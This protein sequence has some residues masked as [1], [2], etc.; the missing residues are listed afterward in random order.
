MEVL[1]LGESMAVLAPSPAGSL[2]TSAELRVGVAGAESNVAIGLALLGA[3]VA[4]RGLV[5]DDPFG[6]RIVDALRASGVDCS[7][8]EVDAERPTGVYFKDPEGE[9]TRVHYYRAGSAA[10]TMGPGFLDRD[11]APRLLHLTGITPA[12]SASCSAL[13]H[14]LVH[15]RPP[16]GGAVGGGG[17]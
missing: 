4:W 16:P 15:A 13:V 2:R 6:H 7:G 10:S 3:D 12:L 14:E 11:A 17:N 5:G 1:C 8:V 9:T